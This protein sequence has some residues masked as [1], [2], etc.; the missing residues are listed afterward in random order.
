LKPSLHYD[1][2]IAGA[3]CAGLSLAMQFIHSGKFGDKHILII[4]QDLKKSNDRT[5]CFWE[6][7]DG[8]FEPIVYLQ[9]QKLLFYGEKFAEELNIAPYHYKMI[10]GIDFYNHCLDC[11]GRQPNFEIRFEKVDH[12][13]S[14]DL[15]TGVM[16]KGAA[17]YCHYVFNSI[18]FEKPELSEKQYWL[19]QH[20]KGMIVETE[21]GAFDPDVATLMDFRTSQKWGTAFCYVLPFSSAKAL[22]EYTI[23]SSELPEKEIYDEGLKEYIQNTLQI[24]SYNITTE[25][26]GMIPMT[27]FRFSPWQNNIINI[28]TSGGQTKASSGY[29][30]NFIQKHSHHIVAQ[31]IK[32]GK[33]FISGTKARF[34]FYDSVL[35]NILNYNTIPGKVIFSRLFQNNTPQ[36]VLKFLDNETTVPEEIRIIATLPVLPFFK[37]GMRQI[38]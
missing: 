31:L 25:E 2:I 28:G 5:W 29:T 11:I 3:G 17:I 9:W 38:F 18:L 33:P 15:A 30:F 32:T 1:Y 14:S 26:F 21:A 35:L 37:A 7:E 10:R 34:Y 19:W 13:F 8:L 27:N 16:V 12:V 6:K 4:D 22:I 36:K 24:Q 23:F 20:F